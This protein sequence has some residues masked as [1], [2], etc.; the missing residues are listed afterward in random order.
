[1][2]IYIPIMPTIRVNWRR[3]NTKT[4][5]VTHT[6]C[7]LKDTS[8]YV[9]AQNL[10]VIVNPKSSL[11]RSHTRTADLS[12]SRFFRNT[13]DFTPMYPKEVWSVGPM[14]LQNN[15]RPP[16][17]TFYNQLCLSLTVRHYNIRNRCSFKQKIGKFT[18]LFACVIN[19]LVYIHIHWQS[20]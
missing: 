20:N 19:L 8:K 9:N 4:N 12:S 14:K 16:P 11:S 3:I 2:Y 6:H 10:Q 7:C 15:N 18:L 5:N 13:S 17:D 1:M